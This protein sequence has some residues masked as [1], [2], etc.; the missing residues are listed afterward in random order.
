MTE[1]EKML[2]RIY[3]AIGDGMAKFARH[4]LAFTV[5]LGAIFGLVWGIIKLDQ[6][7][8][9]VVREIKTEMAAMKREHAEQINM[10][11]AEHRAQ[12]VELWK[13]IAD[14][15]RRREDQAV[16]IAQLETLLKKHKTF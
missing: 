4:S 13:E 16:R 8:T 15:N 11:K 1:Q 3:G 6:H 2:A 9:G 10:I 12:M 7:H 14:C 5:L